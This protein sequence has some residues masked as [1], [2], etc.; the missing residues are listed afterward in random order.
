MQ[1]IVSIVLALLNTALFHAHAQAVHVATS[2]APAGT[3]PMGITYYEPWDCLL[4]ANQTGG[5]TKITLDGGVS[6]FLSGL[7]GAQHITTDLTGNI[8]TSGQFGSTVQV[9]NPSGTRI[10]L[11]VNGKFS[12]A[13]SLAFDGDGNLYVGSG[14]FSQISKVSP[15][16]TRT[17]TNF[18]SG[19]SEPQQ[20]EWYDGFLYVASRTADEVLK[21][22]PTGVESVFATG[23]NNP[24]GLAFDNYGQL[25]VSNRGTG[26][27][28]AVGYDGSRTLYATGIPRAGGIAFDDSN[29]MFITSD[30]LST[31]T[32]GFVYIVPAVPEPSGVALLGGVA[33]LALAR[34]RRGR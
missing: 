5:V 23:F 31:T 22:S 7:G 25:Y 28:D 34:R 32:Q 6:T 19:I 14:G 11:I 17:V 16:P 12:S 18:A 8:Y 24:Y 33:M 26:T 4:V 30:S 3:K 10:E 2:F 20:A 9:H 13:T 27:V 15:F 29:N 1:R 21:I